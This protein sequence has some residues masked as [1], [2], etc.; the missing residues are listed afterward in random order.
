MSGFLT[1]LAHNNRLPLGPA[2]F[3]SLA[4][5]IRTEKGLV[6]GVQGLAATRSKA[7]FAL[8]E[9]GAAEGPDLGDVLTKLSMLFDYVSSAERQQ[10]EHLAT[11]RLHFKAIRT[12]EEALA[13]LK[14]NQ[15][16]LAS[17]IE[18]QDR[19]VSKMKEEN[20]VSVGLSRGQGR[21]VDWGLER[22]GT[23]TVVI[24]GPTHRKSEAFRDAAGNS[25]D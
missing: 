18:A 11:F 12:R 10:A 2:D 24:V 21:A 8:K 17:R 22:A 13:A 14:R 20:K 3:K 1:K 23:L 9:W 19:K 25:R 6:E 5:V 4:E 7:S 15:S 16:S